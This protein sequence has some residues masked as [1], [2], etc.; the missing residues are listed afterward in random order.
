MASCRAGE[1]TADNLARK[2]RCEKI[3][4]YRG[5]YMEVADELTLQRPSEII[6]RHKY[7]PDIALRAI[8]DLENPLTLMRISWYPR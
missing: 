2:A 7:I 8:P 1:V 6:D 5:K 3:N 4:P